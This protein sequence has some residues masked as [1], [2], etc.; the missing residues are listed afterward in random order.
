M[1]HLLP[2]R[3]ILWVFAAFV[4]LMVLAAV[5]MGIAGDEA[6]FQDAAAAVRWS[7]SLATGII[8][9]LYASWRWIPPVQN[10]IF[11]YLGGEWSGILNYEGKNGPGERD[12]TLEVK[13]TLFGLHLMLDSKESTSW[14]LAVHAERHPDFDRY[15]L[16]YVYLNERKEG[17]AGAGE[18]YRELAVMR[19]KPG[20]RME[21]Q[22]DYFTDTHRRGTLHLARIKR[23][24]RWKLWR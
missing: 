20:K 3:L 4:A 19:V 13:H 23:T 16:Y 7:S 11:P 12:V 10:M 15:R 22:G 21:L 17:V 18:R 24:P 1:L 9:L 14:T 5:Y 6:L 2:I 8:V